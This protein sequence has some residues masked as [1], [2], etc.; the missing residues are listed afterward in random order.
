MKKNFEQHQ[1]VGQKIVGGI[2]LNEQNY[3]YFRRAYRKAVKEK[4]DDFMWE[5][6]TWYTKYAKYVLEAMELEPI[7]KP[8]I[9]ESD[10]EGPEETRIG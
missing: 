2:I 1:Y 10:P 6:Q 9:D 3:L 5:G 7:I 8:C 4:K